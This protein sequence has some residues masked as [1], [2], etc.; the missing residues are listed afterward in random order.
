[1]NK[2]TLY[3]GIADQKKASIDLLTNQVTVAQNVVTEQQAIVTALTAKAAQFKSYLDAAA[4]NRAI[5]QTNMTLGDDA[6]SNAHNLL[7]SSQLVND[8]TTLASTGMIA[9]SDSMATLISQLVFSGEIIDKAIVTVNKQKLLNPLI[10]DSLITYL[11]KAAT[12]TNNAVALTLTALQSCYAANATLEESHC[13]MEL[14]VLQAR[15]LDEK[16]GQNPNGEPP[17]IYGLGKKSTGIIGLLNA[18]LASAN[19]VYDAALKN[20]EC[21]NKQLSYAQEQLAIATTA[22]ASLKA[23]LAAANAAAYAS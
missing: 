20:N 19:K 2:N 17:L 1:M 21:V 13:S 16:M 5:A 8:Q 23:G 11:N 4:G 15:K 22:L 18:A 14:C 6:K 7:T 10:P 12:D 3:P 9:A